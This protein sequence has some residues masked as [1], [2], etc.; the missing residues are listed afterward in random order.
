[1]EIDPF[2]IGLALQGVKSLAGIGQFIAGKAKQN[3]IED[4]KYTR[5]EEAVQAENLARS[6]ARE[7]MTAEAEQMGREGIGTSMATALKYGG[8]NNV[9]DIARQASKGYMQMAAEDEQIRRA[10]QRNLQGQLMQSAQYSD[11]EW[12]ENVLRPYEEQTAEAQALTGAGLQN[13][14]GG[15]DAMGSMMQT[16]ATYDGMSTSL[17]GDSESTGDAGGKQQPTQEQIELLK[18]I[19]GGATMTNL[20]GIT[21]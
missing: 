6:M 3:K 17:F 13:I 1:M 14:F 12:E 7:G 5:P 20:T 10:N 15:V 9:A 8:G 2:G 11:R 4:I 19:F 16:K 18:K 21:G